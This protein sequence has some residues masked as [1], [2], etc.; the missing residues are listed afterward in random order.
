MTKKKKMGD[1]VAVFNSRDCDRKKAKKI[2]IKAFDK[3][4]FQREIQPS[5]D[6]GLMSIFKKE[7]TPERVF[8]VKHLS[9][10]RNEESD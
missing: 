6:E 10:A 5:L 1:Y 3:D 4:T 9:M 8:Y 2:F 7:P